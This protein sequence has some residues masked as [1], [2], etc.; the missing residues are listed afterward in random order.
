[1]ADTNT[2]NTPEEQDAAHNPGEAH[3]EQLISGRKTASSLNNQENSA[4]GTPTDSNATESGGVNENIDNTRAKEES[5]PWVVGMTNQNGPI[6][7][8]KLGRVLLNGMK[9]K[10]P[11]GVIAAIIFGGGG[12]L[13]FFGFTLLPVGIAEHFTNDLNDLDAANHRKT[14]IMFGKKLGG[15]DMSKKMSV[16]SSVVS[17]RCKFKTLDTKLVDKFEKEGFKFGE[18]TTVGDRVGFAHIEFPDGTI[19]KNVNEL[20]S[21]LRNSVVALSAFNTV[22][23]I[24]NAIFVLGKWYSNVLGK[25]GL[26]KAKKIEG[27]TKDKVD[28]S[29][30][31]SVKGEK[32]TVQTRA[33]TNDPADDSEEAKRKAAENNSAGNEMQGQINE[34]ITK[35]QKLKTLSLKVSNALAIPQ[36]ICLTYNMASYIG[37]LA[38]VKKAYMFAAFA[39]IFLTLAATI[40]AS[41]ATDQEV[42]KGMSII[43]PSE[44]P[45]KVLNPETG[46]WEANPDIGENVTDSEAYRVVAYGDQINLL[47]IAKTLFVAAGFL[48]IIENIVKTINENFPGGKPAIKTTCKVVNSTAATVV[49]FLAAPFISAILLAAIQV[50][51]IE[52]WAAGLVNMAIDAAAGADITAGAIGST[53]GNL[54]FIGTATI[55]GTAAMRFGLKPSTLGKIRQNMKSSRALLEQEVAMKTYEASKTP[56]DIS[57]RYSFLGSMAYQ[58]AQFMPSIGRQP[59]L[60]SAGKVFSAVP[61]SFKAI[62]KNVQAAASMPV[63]N[64]SE[65]RFSQCQ[66]PVYETFKDKFTPDMF[67][68][69]RYAPN[70]QTDSSSAMAINLADDMVAVDSIGQATSSA[71]DIDPD[72]VAGYL[73][74]R[75]QIDQ[76]TGQPIAGTDFEKFTKNCTERT[77]PWGN[78]STPIEEQNADTRWYTGEA[79]FDDTEFNKIAY[80]WPG[81]CSIQDTLDTQESEG[82]IKDSGAAGGGGAA[83]S[84]APSGDAKQMALAIAQM[85]ESQTGAIKFTNPATIAGLKKFAASDGTP[86]NPLPLSSC[87]QPFSPD[88]ALLT[89]MLTLSNKYNI[90][91]NNIG[92]NDDRDFC[93]GGQHPKGA[94]I[95]IN[96]IEMKS[97]GKAGPGLNFNAQQLPIITSYA[98]DWIATLAPNRGGVGQL[99][100]GG[101]RVTPPPGATGINGNL[102]FTD[103]CDHLH[104]DARVR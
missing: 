69:I 35:G 84:P 23:N 2:P 36:L 17:I 101:F 51:P 67:C 96:M 18:K 56:L 78:T 71:T 12:A 10:G 63:A 82:C 60:A 92:F 102:H 66:D 87:G 11:L 41:A 43:S 83:P 37:T 53:A 79:C 14:V 21:L 4:A 70:L 25:L 29:Y 8:E 97:G 62:T 90:L 22:Y 58:L 46:Q 72:V 47:G 57:N 64:Y 76:V 24:K 98:N 73:L 86:A 59:A 54:L 65:T 88:P 20:N 74:D 77:E 52:E 7:A 40:K 55:M 104:I 45:E 75:G 1:M 19:V 68:T 3:Y 80:D 38:K 89:V 81:Y 100:C 93:D 9:K 95:D 39:M 16:C 49:S 28:K 91:V 27:D 44:Y 33:G 32:G 42:A 13:G 94:A 85:A 99:G 6:R 34:S 15:G 26:T 30:K 31:E 48:G 103:T 50:F 5:T 61:G